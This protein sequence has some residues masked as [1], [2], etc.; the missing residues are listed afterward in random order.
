MST[1]LGFEDFLIP[2]GASIQDVQ[3][4]FEAALN[5]H[6]W[7]TQKKAIVPIAYPTSTLTNYIN[8]LNPNSTGTFAGAYNVGS[9][10]IGVQLPSAFTPTSMYI[11]CGPDGLQAPN[12]FIIQYSA[13]GNTW[14][15]LPQ[16]WTETNWYV[17]EQ[18]KYSISGASAYNYWRI[19]VSSANSATLTV[20][21]WTLENALGHR[22]SAVNFLDVIPPASDISGA[23]PIGNSDAM[24]VLRLTFT[25]TTLSF[26][27]L[28][29]LKVGVP[30]MI[31][32][33]EKTGGE[34][35]GTLTVNGATVSGSTGTLTTTA[36]QNLRSLYEAVRLSSNANFTQWSW[37]YQTPSPQNADDAS[38][39]IYGINS[40]ASAWVPISTNTNVYS[41]TVSG[42]CQ[43]MP[44][45]VNMFNTANTTLTIDLINGFVYYLQICSR[46][47]AL[48]TKTNSAFYGPI[49]AVYGDNT[50][51]LAAIPTTGFGLKCNPIE[52]LIGWDDIATNS[53]S[54]AKVCHSWGVSN[55]T[56]K[57]IANVINTYAY[58]NTCGRSFGYGRLRDKISDYFQ[59]AGYYEPTVT[60][61]GS[62]L[63]N[64]ANNTGNDYQIHRVNCVGETITANDSSL[65]TVIPALDTQDWY[66]FVGSATD[67]ALLLV[68]DTMITTTGTTTIY[69]T[70]VAIAVSSTTAFQASGY[71]VIEGEIIHYSGLSGG[72]TFV[73]CT[74]GVYGTTAVAHF[75]G[76]LVCQG[77]WLTKINGGALLC[78]Y[79]KPV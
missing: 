21:N 65:N 58:D 57:G 12:V 70:D 23:N 42:P 79:T 43:P 62:G 20:A 46:G 56:V 76:D 74:R 13:D 36:K 34:V 73:G 45:P 48:A 50:K 26:S 64:G 4:T 77:L 53:G 60:L 15:P 72:N 7:Q 78:G 33:W 17:N 71:I 52:L 2:L 11:T 30:Q 27:S 44:Q 61:F 6:T 9:G 49:H 55:Q 38:D 5:S 37:E 66:K 68:A 63:F 67:E 18:R 22:I 31:A 32:V 35:A 29:Y 8:A 16:S 54:A 14:T 75:S 3:D 24:E 25:G 59:H 39:Y 19:V 51:A 10:I 47:I 28:Q 40:S 1:F 69:P 41:T